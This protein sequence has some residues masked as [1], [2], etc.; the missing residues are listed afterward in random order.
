MMPMAM[1]MPMPMTMPAFQQPIT[2]TPETPTSPTP[3]LMQ[4]SPMMMPF[5]PLYNVQGIN[6]RPPYE[7]KKG[8]NPVREVWPENLSI[9][10]IS[11]NN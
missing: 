8:S 5:M 6:P 9:V 7:G 10:Q 4:Q 2:P 3:G 11:T 1:P